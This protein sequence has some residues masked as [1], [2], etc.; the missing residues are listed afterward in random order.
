MTFPSRAE[1]K[2]TLIFQKR[3]QRKKRLRPYANAPAHPVELLPI[4][5]HFPPPLA[6][7]PPM[8]RKGRAIFAA[9]VTAIFLLTA[10]SIRAADPLPAPPAPRPL[11]SDQD[12]ADL[13]RRMADAGDPRIIPVALH[14]LAVE[15]DGQ[16]I[17]Y[18]SPRLRASIYVVQTLGVREALPLLFSAY[19][20]TTALG[21][22][23]TRAA[24]AIIRID[25]KNLTF[26]REV[27]AD[28]TPI[29]RTRE[30]YGAAEASARLADE[31]DEDAAEIFLRGYTQYLEST[32]KGEKVDGAYHRAINRTSN[33]KIR[34]RLLA[35][36]K[37]F[38]T[39]P[40]YNRLAI[41]AEIIRMNA[42]PQEK[43]L[44]IALDS[45]EKETERF[46][47]LSSLGLT[48]GV[49][50]LAS[51]EKADRWSPDF[52]AA[53]TRTAAPLPA[54]RTA[55]TRQ[56]SSTRK[57]KPSA[58]SRPATGTTL[59]AIQQIRTRHRLGHSTETPPALS[60]LVPT[61]P[62]RQGESI[63]RLAALVAGS[64]NHLTTRP[65]AL[66]D[67][68]GHA[69][70]IY[71]S[72]PEPL[73]Q[74]IQSLQPDVT[75]RVKI[76]PKTQSLL[77][78]TPIS[79]TPGEQSPRGYVL[80]EKKTLRDGDVERLAVVLNKLSRQIV[81]RVPNRSQPG[82]GTHPDP[83]LAKALESLK[84]GDVVTARI[85]QLSPTAGALTMLTEIAPYQPALTAQFVAW[86]DTPAG[87][88][89]VELLVGREKRTYL[90]PEPREAV[91]LPV[92]PETRPLFWPGCILR[93]RPQT[94]PQ[95]SPP[96]LYDFDVEGFIEPNPQGTHVKIHGATA[97]LQGDPRTK[98]FLGLEAIFGKPSEVNR[99]QAGIHRFLAGQGTLP[100]DV[101]P[102]TRE[103]LADAIKTAEKPGQRDHVSEMNRIFDRHQQTSDKTIR[104]S[105]EQQLFLMLQQDSA[106]TLADQERMRND[107]MAAL[108]KEQYQALLT[109]G[110]LTGPPLQPATQPATLTIR[111]RSRPTTLP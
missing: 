76:D 13:A 46:L 101:T 52:Q 87:E 63:M 44:Q 33:P 29:H 93:I 78:I 89:A 65:V 3:P 86:A 56:A 80:V 38:P 48:G 40:A 43:R 18:G 88:P 77:E 15:Q 72:A 42:L 84:P 61:A 58:A 59:W 54:T 85:E 27:L 97:T 51:L 81:A 30:S 70:N 90:L 73:L 96:R 8:Q 16:P 49:E 28:D 109:L 9:T 20:S 94:S 32:Q 107:I 1:R 79:T 19:D 25:P 26:C 64:E 6:K 50:A 35:L 7:L 75:V 12:Q 23:K 10:I 53:A 21:D 36:R 31:G 100:G 57:P 104:R 41:D 22:A 47:A 24:A 108:T 98:P 95:Q 11:L 71:L 37:Q 34:L 66:A 67:P 83:S 5:S 103:K 110:R 82:S 102:R 4:L 74:Y 17:N 55:V 39:D 60:G 68:A 91:P 62:L 45:K 111:P 14:W 106:Q 2:G 99:A 92:A 105:T 69:P